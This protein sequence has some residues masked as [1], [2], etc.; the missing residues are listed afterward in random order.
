MQSQ[1]KSKNNINI[2]NVKRKADIL[3]LLKMNN[4]TQKA[5]ALELIVSAQA[6]NRFIAGTSKSKKISNYFQKRFGVK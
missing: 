6:V 5:I 3:Y 4:V 2:K 1:V